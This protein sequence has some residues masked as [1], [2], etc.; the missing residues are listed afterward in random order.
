MNDN[1]FSLSGILEI[2]I[3]ISNAAIF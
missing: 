2:I 1:S 3:T